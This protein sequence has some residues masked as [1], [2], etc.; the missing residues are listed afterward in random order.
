[1][2]KYKLDGMQWLLI[3][4]VVIA[5]IL[6][7]AFPYKYNSLTET[8][9]YGYNAILHWI[10]LAYLIR[11]VLHSFGFEVYNL[12]GNLIGVSII[13]AV[14][15]YFKVFIGKGENIE[16]M[17]L[18]VIMPVLGILVVLGAVLLDRF[19]YSMEREKVK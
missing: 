7:F 16:V 17:W 1:M 19:T 15:I 4:S 5:M 11:I 3:I 10:I 18:G 2:V 13:M 14:S 6:L 9:K 12:N 8:T